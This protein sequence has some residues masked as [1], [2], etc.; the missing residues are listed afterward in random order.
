MAPAWVDP[1]L[2]TPG[3]EYVGLVDINRENAAKLADKFNLSRNI[4]FGSLAEAIEKTRPDAVFDVTIPAAH[5]AVTIEAL[6]KGCHVLGEKPMSD[7]LD[8]ARKMV[9]AAKASGKLYAVIQ[10]RRYE[11]AIQRINGF[12]GLGAIG[13]PHTFHSDF[14]IGAHFGGFRDEMP[15]PL[16]V[17]M[18]IHTFDAAR[19]MGNLDPVAVYCHAFNPS[20]SWYK[21]DASAVAIFEMVDKAGLPVVYCYR[22]SWCAEGLQTSWESNWRIIG[23]KGTLLWDGSPEIKAQA[24]NPSG[25]HGFTSEMI[26]LAVPDKHVEH[27]HHAGLIREFV[28]C[29]RTGK[30]P[31]TICTD[32]IKSLAMVLAAVESAATKTRTLVRW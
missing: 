19:Y 14:F 18:A 15:H 13:R 1:A 23:E 8:N 26:D 5:A 27:L 10:N 16:I 22:G 17:D 30:T 25:K 4:V 21:G 3:L 31:Q 20:S 32:N 6:G 29:I 28:D 11:S 2:K 7:S 9:E 24:I 12:L